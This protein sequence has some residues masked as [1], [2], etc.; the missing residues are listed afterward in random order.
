MSQAVINSVI[1]YHKFCAEVCVESTNYQHV[2][3][4]FLLFQRNTEVKFC[5][6]RIYDNPPYVD[7]ERAFR[8]HNIRGYNDT[9]AWIALSDYVLL[10]DDDSAWKQLANK[11]LFMHFM[12]CL[13]N[14]K[15]PFPEDLN[16]R[17]ILRLFI[18]LNIVNLQAI[19]VIELFFSVLYNKAVHTQALEF[20]SL[21][22]D[23]VFDKNDRTEV[24]SVLLGGLLRVDV[25]RFSVEVEL[26]RNRDGMLLTVF[27]QKFIKAESLRP[28][29]RSKLKYSELENGVLA[30]LDSFRS[31]CD[32]IRFPNIFSMRQK[33]NL[34][35]L[36]AQKDI[37]HDTYLHAVLNEPD[38]KKLVARYPVKNPDPLI[39]SEVITNCLNTSDPFQELHLFREQCFNSF[40]QQQRSTLRINDLLHL[41]MAAYQNTS[42]WKDTWKLVYPVLSIQIIRDIEAFVLQHPF[43]HES[44]MKLVFR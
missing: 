9:S 37:S 6:D 3:T 32:V 27:K 18:L 8:L 17:D 15:F 1:L 40:S 10:T 34:Y 2:K 19:H 16:K 20:F 44:I 41:Y 38:L 11:G 29:L 28:K 21:L 42:I 33:K 13:T 5:Y 36:M 23:G 43:N 35:F 22:A 26:Q 31:W 12:R 24:L 30:N 39:L 7:W 4:M 14:A 25:E